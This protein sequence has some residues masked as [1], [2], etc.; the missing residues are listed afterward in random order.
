MSSW[1]SWRVLTFSRCKASHRKETW[2]QLSSL[3]MVPVSKPLIGNLKSL[4]DAFY[5]SVYRVVILEAGKKCKV[6]YC[7][8]GNEEMIG[9]EELLEPG[10]GPQLADTAGPS[11]QISPPRVLTLFTFSIVNFFASP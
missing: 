4:S 11:R 2:R 8:Y 6:R 3:K 9:A 5:F 10:P 7:D 1:T